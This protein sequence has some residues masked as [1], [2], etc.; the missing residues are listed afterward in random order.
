MQI[1]LEIALFSQSIVSVLLLEKSQY[2]VLF[3]LS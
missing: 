3:F 1:R 2:N